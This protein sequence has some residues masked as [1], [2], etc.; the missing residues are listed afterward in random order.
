MIRQVAL[1]PF[2]HSEFNKSISY[3]GLAASSVSVGM[4]LGSVLC[5][6]LLQKKFLHPCTIMMIGSFGVCLGLLVCFPQ[7]NLAVYEIAPILA[8]PGALL[9]GLGDPLMG[10]AALKTMYHIQVTLFN[11]VVVT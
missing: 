9:A 1:T 7:Q 10:M 11:T 6:I 3:G 8:F 5:G 2:L 4:A